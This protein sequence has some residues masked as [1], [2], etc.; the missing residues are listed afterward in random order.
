MP[1]DRLW[2][3]TRLREGSAELGLSDV[4]ARLRPVFREDAETGRY[5][6]G[7]DLENVEAEGAGAE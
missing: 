6:A 7:F 1:R 4:R 2:F 5:C 3:E